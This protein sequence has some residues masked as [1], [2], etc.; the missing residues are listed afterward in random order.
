MEYCEEGDLETL[1]NNKR[2]EAKLATNTPWKVVNLPID[3]IMK[4]FAQMCL[5]VRYLHGRN[6]LHRDIKALNVFITKAGPVK[7]GDLGISTV[8]NSPTDKEKDYVGTRHYMAPEIV[9]K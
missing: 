4:I 1:L 8:L 3:E 7:L 9:Q 2:E 6:I 5:G